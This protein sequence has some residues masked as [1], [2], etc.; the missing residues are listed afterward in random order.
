MH[1]QA[2]QSGTL[3]CNPSSVTACLA[4]QTNSAQCVG[5][6]YENVLVYFGFNTSNYDLSPGKQLLADRHKTQ[7]FNA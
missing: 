5:N 2:M 7:C 3:G 4:P 6:N 1:S